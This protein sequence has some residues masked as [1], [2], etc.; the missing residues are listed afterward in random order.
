MFSV[1]IPLAHHLLAGLSVDDGV[2]IEIVVLNPLHRITRVVA[3]FPYLAFFDEW[4][5]SRVDIRFWGG[6]D[7][8]VIS[9]EDTLTILITR[10]KTRKTISVFIFAWWYRLW[11]MRRKLVFDTVTCGTYALDPD[12]VPHAFAV[13]L[14]RRERFTFL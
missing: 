6:L 7:V 8:E 10:D 3:Y 12:V 13:V 5:I 1:D 9:R 4:T 14:Y 2:A 11:F